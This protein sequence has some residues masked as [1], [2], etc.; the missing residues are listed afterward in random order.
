MLS[1]T[2]DEPEAKELNLALDLV[3]NKEKGN[4][5]R[6]QALVRIARYYLKNHEVPM[7][8]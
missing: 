5:S 6:S 7:G 1:F 3:I 8:A 4:L 2:L